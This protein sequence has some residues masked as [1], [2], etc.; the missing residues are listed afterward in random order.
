MEVRTESTSAP[1]VPPGATT[2]EQLTDL[3]HHQQARWRQQLTDHPE[4]FADLE[5]QV[6]QTFQQLADQVVAGLLAAA[7]SHSAPALDAAQKK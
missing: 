7:T 6:H 3:L 1:P 4:Q 5:V 2:L